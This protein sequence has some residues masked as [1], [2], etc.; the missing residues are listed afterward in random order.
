MSRT[1]CSETERQIIL[2]S[3]GTGG[4]RQAIGGRAPRLATAVDWSRLT[5]TLLSRRLLT[6]LGPRILDLVEG[7][8]NDEFVDTLNSALAAGRRQGALLELISMRLMAALADAGVR[9]SPL[10]GPRLGETIYGDPGRR[11]SSDIDLLVSPQQLHAAVEVVRSLGY[12]APTDHVDGRGMPL[13]HFA[14]VH[15]RREL[16]PVELHWR[17]HWYERSF[18][19]DRLLTPT[20]D[21][22]GAWRP[23]PGDEL[24]ALLLFYAR[25]GFV[26]LRLATDLGAWWDT[27]ATQLRAE[28]LAELVT[29]YPALARVLA[30]AVQVAEKVVGISAQRLLRDMPNLGLRERGAIRL[31]NPNP[32][33][34]QP[35]LYADMGMVDAL[36]MPRGDFTAFLRR[37]VLPPRKV[38]KERARRVQ[39][40]RGS[41]PFGHGVRVLVRYALTMTRLVR[42]PEALRLS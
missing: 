32:R 24:A 34:S 12:E 10:K 3:A 15:Q 8:A 20:L 38:L 35:Q 26:D 33:T 40:R 17:I 13:L 1:A 42:T 16:P 28:V 39:K 4:R 25:D 37:Q 27:F 7:Q 5:E 14:L 18:A 29:V 36:L 41:T 21:A 9:S 6:V 23:A 30:V 22:L 19:R 11:P 2:L 31:A